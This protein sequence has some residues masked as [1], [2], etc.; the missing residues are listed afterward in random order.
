M[1]PLIFGTQLLTGLMLLANRFVPLALVLLAPF[2]VNSVAF[3]VFLE[4]SGRPMAGMVAGTVLAL[5][6]THRSSYRTLLTAK[7]AS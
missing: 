4:P 1:M 5:A 2:V 6:W 7:A 3:H